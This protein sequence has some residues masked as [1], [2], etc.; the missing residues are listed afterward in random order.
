[1]LPVDN[2]TLILLLWNTLGKFCYFYKNCAKL[3]I[4]ILE[5]VYSKSLM[6]SKIADVMAILEYYAYVLYH[7]HRMFYDLHQLSPHVSINK[8]L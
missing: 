4:D 8:C 7:S 3:S 5:Y 1:M 2:F 6:I